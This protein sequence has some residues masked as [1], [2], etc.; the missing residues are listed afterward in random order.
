M[1]QT[2]LV[3][4]MSIV[5][6]LSFASVNGSKFEAYQKAIIADAVAA[7]CNIYV[8]LNQLSHT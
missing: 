3:L 6:S 4:V 2:L 7:Q 8:D 1:K 5:S